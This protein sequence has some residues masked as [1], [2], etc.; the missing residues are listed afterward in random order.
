MRQER[1]PI[2]GNIIVADALE[3]WG[4]VGGDVTVVK[5]GK[6]YCRGS[7]LGNLLVEDGGR[8]HVYGNVAGDM[9]IQE[10]AK[11]VHSGAVGGDIINRGGRLYVDSTAKVLGRIRTHGNGQTKVEKPLPPWTADGE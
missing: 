10:G 7:I 3:L 6:L 4:N 1:R 9:V 11:V 8:V 5:G 2:A